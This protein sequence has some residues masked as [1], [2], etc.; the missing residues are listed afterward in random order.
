MEKIVCKRWE[1][2]EQALAKIES[3]RQAI[4]EKNPYYSGNALFRGLGNGEWGLQTTLERTRNLNTGKTVADLASYYQMTFAARASIET[5][6][7]REWPEMPDPPQFMERLEQFR[8]MQP[9]FFFIN[10]VP[11]YRYLAYL[12]H[13]GYPSPL[14]DWTASPYVAA[15][16]AFDGMAPGAEFVSVCV[17]VRDSSSSSSSDQSTITLLGPYVRTHRRHMIQQSSYTICLL[18]E[19]NFSFREHDEALARPGALGFNGDFVRIDIP[20]SEQVKA[21][22]YLDSMNINPY[23]LFNTDDSLMRTLSRRVGLYATPDIVQARRDSQD[24]AGEDAKALNS[25]EPTN[26]DQDASSEGNLPQVG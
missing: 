2:F 10:Q 26:S 9:Q 22:K 23:S 25:S 12:R 20:A 15:F 5:F 8:S 11:V 3:I 6:T 24:S 4:L 21:L 1:D 19:D 17:I 18:W 16:F 7:D 13:H 14:L